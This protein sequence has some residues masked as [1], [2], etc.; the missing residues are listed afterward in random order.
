YVDI[1]NEFRTIMSYSNRCSAYGGSCPRVAHFAN[2]LVDYGGATTGVASGTSSS[3]AE[4]EIEPDPECDADNTTNFN[5]KAS[6]TSQFRDSRVTWTG[7]VSSSW[8][9]AGNWTINEGTPGSTTAVNRVPRSF[10]N[11]YIPSGLATYPTITG[12]VNARELVIADGATL[13]MASGTLTVG[14]SWEDSGGFNATGGTVVFSGPIGVAITSASAFND[15][16]IGT[17]SDTS[18][19]SLESTINIDGDLDI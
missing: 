5:T 12:S 18:V 13:N 16:Q 6:I 8:S 15:V 9:T 3:C 10:D 19:V 1:S 14:W 7:A 11:I 4:G 17:G 2:P